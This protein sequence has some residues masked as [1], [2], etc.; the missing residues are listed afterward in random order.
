MICKWSLNLYEMF[1]NNCKD[2]YR[3]CLQIEKR[4]VWTNYI[5]V[6][7]IFIMSSRQNNTKY[8]SLL[9][10]LYV[11]IHLD[12]ELFD[13]PVVA[14]ILWHSIHL[15]IALTQTRHHVLESH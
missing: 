13:I 2:N 5:N 10:F 9:L 6:S 15:P 8:F 11:F 3:K 7:T 4:S 14:R 1:L 12:L